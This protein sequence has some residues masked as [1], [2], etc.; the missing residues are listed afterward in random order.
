MSALGG[1]AGGDARHERTLGTSDVLD[2][3]LNA[4]RMTNTINATRQPGHG[5]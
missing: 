4:S 1:V 2:A 3:R 5:R